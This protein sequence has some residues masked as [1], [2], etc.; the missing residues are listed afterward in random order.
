MRWQHEAKRLTSKKLTQIFSLNRHM[1]FAQLQFTK[2]ASLEV[3]F[4]PSY[5]SFQLLSS[6]A[7]STFSF[8]IWS[9]E[10]R[11]KDWVLP[12][13]VKRLKGRLVSSGSYTAGSK[14]LLIS[15][16]LLVLSFQLSG[17]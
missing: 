5:C 17:Y 3:K 10:R 7:L 6:L 4:G 16:F 12:S 14:K 1:K 9:F 8:T 13:R 15:G 11:K 2:Q